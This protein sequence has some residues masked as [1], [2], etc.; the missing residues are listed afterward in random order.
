MNTLLSIIIITLSILSLLRNKHK[1]N[2]FL[3]VLAIMNNNFTFNFIANIN[4]YQF[5]S[6]LYLPITLKYYIENKKNISKTLSPFIWIFVLFLFV[7]FYFS[8]IEPW[9]D[10]YDYLRS[11]G[12][13]PIGRSIISLTRLLLDI[14]FIILI[15]YWI[16]RKKILHNY[17]F[18]TINIVLI[19]TV[20]IAIFD[21]MLS[22]QLSELLFNHQLQNLNNRFTGFSLEP[23]YFGRVCSYT[24]MFL[25]VTYKVNPFKVKKFAI[26]FGIIGIILSFSASTLIITILWLSIW[27]LKEKRFKYLIISSFIFIVLWLFVSDL[28]FF[29]SVTI[30]KISYVYKGNSEIFTSEVIVPNEPFLFRRF[31][32]FDRAALNFLYANPRYIFTGVGLDLIQIPSSE[33]MT[34]MYRLDH[35]IITAVPHTLLVNVLSSG[36]LIGLFLIILS[37]FKINKVL[38][39]NYLRNLNLLN[40]I[41]NFVVFTP[42]FFFFIGL[43]LSLNYFKYDE[44]LL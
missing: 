40:Y 37:Y 15:L 13:K 42:F 38:K 7:N 8:M 33:Y 30:D 16:K 9:T 27:L 35:D 41:M 3:V 31:E 20:T 6:L 29:Q 12:Q 25:M 19:F 39:Y 43:S 18:S 32:I 22:K 11:W 4:V 24:L 1:V 34:A 28:D 17:I 2:F 36:G 21:F 44:K 23:R 5:I 26:I 10:K 14:N